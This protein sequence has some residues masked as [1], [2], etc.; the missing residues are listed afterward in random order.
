MSNIKIP[1]EQLKVLAQEYEK[2]GKEKF[3]IAHGAIR[4]DKDGNWSVLEVD[5]LTLSF[6]DAIKG[7]Q[8]KNDIP[9]T[10]WAEV[11]PQIE[12][13]LKKREEKYKEQQA[14]LEEKI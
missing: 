1:F 12:W 2:V 14:S 10:F 8:Y 11:V 9:Y 13:Y 6:V 5:G 4:V 7:M 3:L